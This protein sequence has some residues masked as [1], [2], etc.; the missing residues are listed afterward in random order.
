MKRVFYEPLKQFN[1]A[2]HK[3]VGGGTSYVNVQDQN[4]SG[5]YG[6][7]SITMLSIDDKKKK[8]KPPKDYHS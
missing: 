3:M 1:G 5:N 7:S 4:Q 6:Y 2:V 8:K